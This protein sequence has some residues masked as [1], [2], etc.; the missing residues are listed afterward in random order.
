MHQTA[1][2]PA[3]GMTTRQ[4]LTIAVLACAQL[5][6]VLDVTVV[7]VALPDIGTSLGLGRTALTWVMTIYTTLFG[8]LVLAGGKAADLLGARRTLVAGL[9]VFV[10]ASLASALAR[11]STVLLLGRAVQGV[12]A[13]LLSPS[14]LAVLLSTVSGA[15]RG[16][17]LAVWG[18][19]SAI[20]SAVGVS[21]GG[22]VTS[23]LGWEWIFA[24]NVP[25]GLAILIA[26]PALT[27][28]V[29]ANPARPD[30]PGAALVTAGTALVVYGLVNAGNAGWAAG[31]TLGALAAGV[32]IWA[33]F[34]VVERRTAAPMLRVSLLREPSVVGGAF[35]MIVA[36]GLMIGN[37]FLGSFALQR[38]YGDG[39]LRVGLEFLPVAV[40]VG[41]G[42]QLAGRLLQRLPARVVATA[43]LA[44]AAGGEAA[45]T[46]VDGGRVALV[47]GLTVAAFGIGAVFVT[48]FTSALSSASPDDGGL[49]SAIVSTAHEI[50]GAFGVAV[51][52]SLAA[53][54]LAA[55]SPEPADFSATFGIA[56]I[57]SAVAALVA[58]V[59]VPATRRPEPE[60]GSTP[61]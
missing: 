45:A 38:A 61:S 48:A 47:L 5:M 7:N 40:G 44:L 16:R 37:F 4:A 17:A 52:S 55:V 32:L 12:G 13:A 2:P 18:S 3:R 10:L 20:G 46:I 51:L 41:L 42:A 31:P 14:A 36:T 6:L 54:A 33:V 11:D 27:S 22:V 26:I 53:G 1:A 43:G 56:A 21:L 19:L 58:L 49:R 35:L 15:A 23:A 34:A 60:P 9:A 29:D 30:L 50:G 57:A 25:I 28:K 59:L 39:P 24:I 8:G